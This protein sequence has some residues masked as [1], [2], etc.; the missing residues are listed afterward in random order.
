MKD[1]WIDY[2]KSSYRKFVRFI[3]N[4]KDKTTRS[5]FR[6]FQFAVYASFVI[7]S[8]N[9]LSVFSDEG[10]FGT[11]GD[12][13]GGML[14]PIL[15]FLMFMGLL[16]TIILQQK[17]L[18]LTRNELNNSSEALVEQAQTQ[19][20][21]RFENTFFSL[22][23]QHNEL[24]SELSRNID[25]VQ[26]LDSLH[27]RCMRASN[28]KEAKATLEKYNVRV[29]HYFRTLYQLLK[30]IATKH[31]GSKIGMDCSAESISGVAVTS[32]EKFYSNLVRATLG[33]QITQLVAINCYS[34]D[35]K[36]LKF[37]LLISRYEFLEHMPFEHNQIPKE[38]LFE[39]IDFYGD[40]A[41]GSSEFL[42][43]LRE[44]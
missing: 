37:R 2:H 23:Q 12:F 10:S 39:T 14:N 27:R 16:I 1:K 43:E 34:Q 42:A 35:N 36:Y 32:D 6:L 41:F 15:T 26:S 40:K 17:E 8:I 3:G 31:P 18:R 13:F 21:Q 5:L 25:D 22:L 7:L 4:S 20:K 24:L 19:E 29:G 30:L 33:Y 28:L 11:F 9:L 44:K 38:S